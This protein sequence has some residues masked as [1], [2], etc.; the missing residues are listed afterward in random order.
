MHRCTA[1]VSPP[2]RPA[3]Q[4]RSLAVECSRH[5]GHMGHMGD[6]RGTEE[7]SWCLHTAEQQA[8]APADRR[9]PVGARALQTSR[10]AHTVDPQVPA[11]VTIQHADMA[12]PG[13]M[14]CCGQAQSRRDAVLQPSA[15]I[16]A[17]WWEH[18]CRQ[19]V[20]GAVLQALRGVAGCRPCSPQRGSRSIPTHHPPVK[21]A[22][23][24][25]RAK[26]FGE[27]DLRHRRQGPK[28]SGTGC[29]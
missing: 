28:C 6:P 24:A 7:L 23:S 22:S 16:K 11:S 29:S 2:L 27:D 15:L 17:G 1:R 8:H 14:Q 3:A 20:A 25:L 4:Q 13:D 21:V 9:Q 5:M 26:V 12:G 19:C 18:C 10:C